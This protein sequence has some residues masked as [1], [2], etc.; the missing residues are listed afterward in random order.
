MHNFYLHESILACQTAQ[1]FQVWSNLG[2][3]KQGGGLELSALL[4]VLQIGLTLGENLSELEYACFLTQESHSWELAF[5]II[6]ATMWEKK[7]KIH[8][9]MFTVALLVIAEV[10]GL[11]TGING[12]VHQNGTG[13]IHDAAATD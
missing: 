12:K 4:V 8:S 10:N 5:L 7:N 6:L 13:S 1:D 9:R 3:G 2:V 11:K